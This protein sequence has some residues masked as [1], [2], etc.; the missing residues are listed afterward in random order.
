MEL[1]QEQVFTRDT[2]FC[3]CSGKDLNDIIIYYTIS[4]IHFQQ[5]N[6]LSLT[7]SIYNLLIFILKTQMYGFKEICSYLEVPSNDTLTKKCKS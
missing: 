5:R 4:E 7:S 6:L 1:I 2:Q 3:G